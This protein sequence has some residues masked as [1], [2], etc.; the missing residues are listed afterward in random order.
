MSANDELQAHTCE[1]MSEFYGDVANNVAQSNSQ[2]LTEQLKNGK[3]PAGCYYV[4]LT[5]D[6]V[7]SDLYN[8]YGYFETCEGLV[9]KVLEPS[10][11]YGEWR[12]L[13]KENKQLRKWCEE[14]DALNVAK[15]NK[16]LKD[17]LQKCKVA[18]KTYANED[19]TCGLEEENKCAKHLLAKIDE[20]LK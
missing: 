15:E 2:D 10:P 5:T 1:K 19:E 9:K 3:L 8:P 17:L 16:K 7:I 14:F 11:N 18:F 13:N 4:L 6:E 12:Y 20:V